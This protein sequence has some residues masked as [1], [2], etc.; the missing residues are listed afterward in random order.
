MDPIANTFHRELMQCY[1]QYVA[2][3]SANN[4]ERLQKTLSGCTGDATQKLSSGQ[5]RC[6]RKACDAKCAAYGKVG[7]VGGIFMGACECVAP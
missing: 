2:S 1:R 5:E 7:R 3:Y 4:P 6:E